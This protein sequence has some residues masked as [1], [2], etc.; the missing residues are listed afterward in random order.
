MIKNINDFNRID[1]QSQYVD[2]LVGSLDFLTVLQR[3]REYLENEK[4]KESNENLQAEILHEAPYI[5][6]ERWEEIHEE[7]A[8]H[9]QNF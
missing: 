3:L 5:L 7:E 6:Q 8:Y 9:A 2:H 1:I 4:D